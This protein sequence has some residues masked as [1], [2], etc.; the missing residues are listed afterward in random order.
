M[1]WPIIYA[2]QRSP[3][4]WP[5]PHAFI[6]ERWLAKEGDPLFPIRGA[7]R[8]FEFGP[9]NCIG[10]ELAMIETKVIM[11]L[12]L[13]QFDTIMAHDEFDRSTENT[14]VKTTPEAG[15][16]YQVRT[17]TAKPANGM[18]SRVKRI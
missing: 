1:T 14:G 4:L 10:Q 8:P 7:R 13:R 2:V 3:K 11:V 15:R 17:A 16:A 6:P 5:E 12:M 9:R 18:P